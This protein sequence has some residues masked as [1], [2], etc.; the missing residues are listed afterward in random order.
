[1]REE[2]GL[3]M[4]HMKRDDILKILDDS[5]MDKQMKA[6]IIKLYD[7]GY[8][9]ECIQILRLHKKT[10]LAKMYE[11]QDKVDQFDYLTYQLKKLRN[12]R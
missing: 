10:L 5:D 3:F 12:E 8:Y 4:E 2:K 7:H 1:M 9:L 6:E 11:C